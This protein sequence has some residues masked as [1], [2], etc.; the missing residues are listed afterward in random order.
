MVKKRR[1]APAG[2]QK[3]KVSVK[4]F[5]KYGFAR[6]C[7]ADENQP[8]SHLRGQIH[9]RGKRKIGMPQLNLPPIREDD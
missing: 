8:L 7:D 9:N 6:S 5:S 2:Y 4:Q 3:R 1:L